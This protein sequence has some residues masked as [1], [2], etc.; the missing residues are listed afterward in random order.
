MK[1]MKKVLS[2][3]LAFSLMLVLGVNAFAA[4]TAYSDVA[5]GVWYADAVDYV[6]GQGLMSGTGNNRFAPDMTTELA[7]V[8]SI[9]HRDAGSP[10]P[11]AAPNLGWY[12]EAAA[13]AEQSN[14]LANVN[15][16]FTGVPISREDLVTVLWRDMGSPVVAGEDFAD[17]AEISAYAVQAVDWSRAN[18][19][20]SGKPGNRFDPKCGTTRAELAMILQNFLTKR[21]PANAAQPEPAPETGGKTLVVYFSA[22][23]STKA[24]AET[25]ASTLSADTFEIT[26]VEPY[27]SDDLNWTADGS[28]VNREHDD[29]SLRE[30]PLVSDTAP[31]WDSYDTVFIGYPIWWGIAAW[32]TNG[33]VKANDFTGKTVIPFCTSTSSGLGQSGELLKELAGAGNWLEGERFRSRASESD[34]TEWLGSLNLGG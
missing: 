18:G 27:T 23:G 25:I 10:V 12:A 28:R 8:V 9:L 32:P 1:S 17:E 19:I 21:Q 30:I 20:V 6:S 3:V 24:V 2:L 4:N 22:S 34:I 5:A 11:E 33:F 13:W 31:N 14:L 7:M 16:T 26:P 15:S 29:T